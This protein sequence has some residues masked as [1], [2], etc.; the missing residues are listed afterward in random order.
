M[1]RTLFLL[2]LSLGC[3][4]GASS[5]ATRRP[6]AR[7]GL[8]ILAS[9]ES[10]LEA[11]IPLRFR[12]AQESPV[13]A[14]VPRRGRGIDS[15]VPGGRDWACK[16]RFLYNRV[17]MPRVASCS[18]I[19]LSEDMIVTAFHCISRYS[20]A[21]NLCAISGYDRASLDDET[22]PSLDAYRSCRQIEGC[23]GQ[24]CP[25]VH[26]LELVVAGS[27][28]TGSVNDWAILRLSR[29]L[30]TKVVDR[31]SYDPIECRDDMVEVQGYPD[32]IP[33]MGAQVL[34]D[35]A[36]PDYGMLSYVT[37][38]VSNMSGGGILREGA[39]V[40]MHVSTTELTLENR[41]RLCCRSTE[42]ACNS[43]CGQ[44]RCTEKRGIS[45]KVIKSAYDRALLEMEHGGGTYYDYVE[46]LAFA[47]RE[48]VCD[49]RPGAVDPCLP[50]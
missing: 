8:D 22:Y 39:L 11:D 38:T 10:G 23:E 29:P 13:V 40:G 45:A 6:A 4:Q 49:L 15:K 3:S 34:R 25:V 37:S 5:G 9:L 32:G 42:R 30:T 41:P 26:E 20:S 24:D 12:N 50:G 14:L 33:L 46:P 2:L 27:G 36:T 31:F 44:S 16:D 7:I 18:A 48:P 19:A 43:V 1:R 35:E 21:E 28:P 17:G 47:P